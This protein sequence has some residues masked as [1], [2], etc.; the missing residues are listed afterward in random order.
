MKIY[1]FSS[2]FCSPCKLYKPIF[3]QVTS[4][5]KDIYP[6]III[7]EVDIDE[8]EDLANKFFITGIPTTII[9]DDNDRILYKE[10]GILSEDKLK[11]LIKSANES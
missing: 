4:K 5:F 6:N 2:T 9:T 8:E 3:E 7:K 11:Q 1:K 10:T